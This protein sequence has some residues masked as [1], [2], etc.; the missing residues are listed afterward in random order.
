MGPFDLF[1]NG[2]LYNSHRPIQ[3][4]LSQIA[5]VITIVFHPL[6]L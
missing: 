5:S 6:V 4:N 1:L 3:L 2:E